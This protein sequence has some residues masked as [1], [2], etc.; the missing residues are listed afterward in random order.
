MSCTTRPR[1]LLR[2]ADANLARL[3]G[4]SM[5][6]APQTLQD[7]LPRARRATREAFDAIRLDH[8]DAA[9]IA[10]HALERTGQA[11][12]IALVHDLLK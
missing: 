6:R 3:D 11:V 2:G 12:A 9:A 1:E 8:P 4:V 10:R 5:R 7:A